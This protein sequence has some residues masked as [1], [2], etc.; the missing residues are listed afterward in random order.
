MKNVKYEDIISFDALMNSADQCRVGVMWKAST[1]MFWQNQINWCATLHE[2]LEN[3]TFKPYGFY[4]FDI[5]ER[6]KKRHIRAVKLQERVVQKSLVQNGLRPLIEPRLIYDNSAS[7]KGK[8]TQF[9]LNRLRQHLAQHYRKYGRKGGILIMDYSSYFDS[10][11]HEILLSMLKKI[12]NDNRVF[13]LT[14]MFINAFPGDKGLGLGSEVSQTS[15][16]FYPNKIDHYIKERL[17]IKGYGRY[18][19]DSYI[20]HQ[21]IEYLKYCRKEVER[22]AAELGLKLNPKATQIVKFSSASFE[23]LKKRFCITSS[24][25]I[26]MRLSRKNVTRHRRRLRR[27]ID[28]GVDVSTIRQSHNSWRGYAKQCNSYRTICNTENWLYKE[29]RNKKN[30]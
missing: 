1:Q 19:D 16:I 2:Q 17:H 3:E 4:E 28:H 22:M 10:I 6:G 15:A 29:W 23:Y 9:A 25:K 13:A 26:L 30:G 7:I 11:D 12:I 14:A 18:M 8:G 20:I 27:M 5:N 21:D 24:G